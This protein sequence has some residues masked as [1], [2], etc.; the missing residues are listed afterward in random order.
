MAFNKNKRKWLRDNH[1][2]I[3]LKY[4][5]AKLMKEQ[6]EETKSFIISKWKLENIIFKSDWSLRHFNSYLNAIKNFCFINFDHEFEG[7]TL[8]LNTNQARPGL[9]KNGH[10][11]LNCDQVYEEW[12][13]VKILPILHINTVNA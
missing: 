2:Q 4:K 11:H 12:L 1:E 5:E 3:E 13:H 6:I 10:I 7:F 8:V 9:K